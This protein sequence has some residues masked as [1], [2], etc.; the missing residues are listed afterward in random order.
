[1]VEQ[2]NTG[3]ISVCRC[4]KCAIRAFVLLSK[5]FVIKSDFAIDLLGDFKEVHL[6][7]SALF[8]PLQDKWAWFLKA[9]SNLK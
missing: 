5:N 7:F 9:L 3:Y 4:Y 8:V 6:T 2:E 1:M